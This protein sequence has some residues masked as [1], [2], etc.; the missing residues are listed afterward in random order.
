MRTATQIVPETPQ[1]TVAPKPHNKRLTSLDIFRGITMMMM[2][3]VNNPGDWNNIYYPFAHAQWHGCSMTDLIF[4]FFIFMMGVSMTF[5]LKKAKEQP[6]LRPQAYKKAGIRAMKLIG[7]GLLLNLLPFFDFAH[8]R[9]MGV[10]QRIG[11][12][13][14][15][16]VPLFF[17]LDWKGLLRLSSIIL[18][19]YYLLLTRLPIPGIGMPDLNAFDQNIG[20]YVDFKLMGAHLWEH[21]KTWD[22]EGLIST[23]PAIVTALSGILAGLW[24]GHK[25]STPYACVTGLMVAGFIQLIAGEWFGLGFP[26]NK[27][28]WTS[29][30]VILTSGYAWLTLGALYWLLDIY[31]FEHR[32]LTFFKIFGVNAIS[33]FI[34]SNL[35]VK[36]FEAFP[37]NGHNLLSLLYQSAYISWMPAKTASLAYAVTLVLLNAIPMYYLYRKNIIFKV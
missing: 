1:D 3:L 15:I 11:I 4:P 33:A 13:F 35:L 12:L 27:S 22:P 8:W 34:F 23:I 10:L 9:F 16:S 24:I 18:I 36:C 37:V 19:G 26:I 21:A 14:I 31:R 28:L 32:G 5:S 6:E 29:S 25:K 2:V 30:F 17:S 7:I 20:A